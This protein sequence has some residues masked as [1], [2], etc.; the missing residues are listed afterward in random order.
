MHPCSDNL[1]KSRR[2]LSKVR[3]Y[4]RSKLVISPELCVDGRGVGWPF[5]KR[6][7]ARAPDLEAAVILIPL[8]AVR[9]ADEFLSLLAWQDTQS[10]HG[11][12]GLARSRVRWQCVSLALV[13]IPSCRHRAHAAAFVL[14]AVLFPE[15]KR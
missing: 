14:P 12:A 5:Q 8:A 1:V 3:P 13:L 9:C 15:I 7:V 11:A 10:W 4:K 6:G 2:T